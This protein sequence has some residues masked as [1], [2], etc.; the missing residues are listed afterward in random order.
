[1]AMGVWSTVM[2]RDQYNGLVEELK[3]VTF[4]TITCSNCKKEIPLRINYTF[5]SCPFCGNPLKK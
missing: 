3:G 5:E 2:A 1:M 4:A